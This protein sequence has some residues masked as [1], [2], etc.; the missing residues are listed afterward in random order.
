MP[1]SRIPSAHFA[2]RRRRRAHC[3]AR[4][5]GGS[6]RARAGL[7]CKSWRR[8]EANSPSFG[9]ADADAMAECCRRAQLSRCLGGRRELDLPRARCATKRARRR[10]SCR[11]PRRP[12]RHYSTSG[13]ISCKSSEADCDGEKMTSGG[14]KT[15]V[16][17]ALLAGSAEALLLRRGAWCSGKARVGSARCELADCSRPSGLDSGL[18]DGARARHRAIPR[19]SRK[20]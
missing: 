6:I 11:N 10:Y 13:R 14:L 18:D 19:N 3:R 5:R 12:S 9:S 15:V 17:C 8:A 16:L 4:R 1:T 7:G 20:N 2:A